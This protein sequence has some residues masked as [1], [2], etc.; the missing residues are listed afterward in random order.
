MKLLLNKAHINEKS[1]YNIYIDHT[2]PENVANDKLV[3][4]GGINALQELGK[5]SKSF[6]KNTSQIDNLVA[7]DGS[8]ITNLINRKDSKPSFQRTYK[9]SRFPTCYKDYGTEDKFPFEDDSFSSFKSAWEK[10][11]SP[12]KF[13]VYLEFVSL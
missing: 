4:G 8:H 1:W 11:G 5:L 2:Q 13:V 7:N 6:P 3:F 10:I 12:E 9:V